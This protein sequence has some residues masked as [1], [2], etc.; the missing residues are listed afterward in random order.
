NDSSIAS[1]RRSDCTLAAMCQDSQ[2]RCMAKTL[3]QRPLTGPIVAWILL[4]YGSQSGLDCI[5][6]DNLGKPHA[7]PLC[8]T[9][10]VR[11]VLGRV[12][13]Y[14]TPTRTHDTG[15]KTVG[16]DHRFHKPAGAFRF[17]DRLVMRRCCPL[18]DLGRVTRLSRK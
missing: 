1:I 5:T 2:S 17:C 16:A 12:I 6:H 14:R 4:P 9:R 15:S 13:E 7:V 18:W 8:K 11:P 10:E 3:P